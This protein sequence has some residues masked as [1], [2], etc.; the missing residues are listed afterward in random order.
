MITCNAGKW[1][2][3]FGFL[4]GFRPVSGTKKSTKSTK[5]KKKF[6]S[7]PD[8]GGALRFR[9][10]NLSRK[11]LFPFVFFVSFVVTLLYMTGLRRS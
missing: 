2:G 8:V 10:H 6:T 3:G 1:D 11:V 9:V 5:D 7:S 4:L